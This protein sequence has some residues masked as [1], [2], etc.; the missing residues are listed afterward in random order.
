VLVLNRPTT[1]Q[2][3]D[4]VVVE[5]QPRGGSNIPAGS[6]VAIFIGRFSG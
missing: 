6:L 5:Q 1:N 3:Q 2:G 4:G